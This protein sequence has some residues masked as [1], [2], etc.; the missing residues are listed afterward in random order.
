M[1]RVYQRKSSSQQGTVRQ[2]WNIPWIMN[3]LFLCYLI[4]SFIHV[5]NTLDGTAMYKSG[6]Q[7]VNRLHKH[8]HADTQI[9]VSNLLGVS[10]SSQG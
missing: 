1:N 5:P 8:H 10:Q 4:S 2:K 7:P 9:H 3:F 6:L